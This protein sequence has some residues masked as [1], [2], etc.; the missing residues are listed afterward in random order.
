MNLRMA[1]IQCRPPFPAGWRLR[2]GTAEIWS[3]HRFR[4]R[5]PGTTRTILRLTTTSAGRIGTALLI[6]ILAMALM[7][8]CN[9]V[10]KPTRFGAAEREARPIPSSGFSGPS[11]ILRSTWRSARGDSRGHSTVHGNVS[12]PKSAPSGYKPAMR[13]HAVL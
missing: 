10:D 6:A 9:R 2:G 12:Y 4:G 8:A 1:A 3:T 7:P 11:Q 5:H 13:E